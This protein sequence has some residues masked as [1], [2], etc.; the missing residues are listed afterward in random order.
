MD[1]I[2]QILKIYDETSSVK[3]IVKELGISWQRAVKILTTEGYVLNDNHEIILEMYRENKPLHEIAARTGLT[4]KTIQ[5]YLPAQK[6]YYN[7]K[8]SANALRIRKCRDKKEE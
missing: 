4:E 5:A 2:K 6:P 3:A 7:Y 8:P 1:E